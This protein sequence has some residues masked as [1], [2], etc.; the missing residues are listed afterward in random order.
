MIVVHNAAAY[1]A[2]WRARQQ[3]QAFQLLKFSSQ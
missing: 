1:T 3:Q 2:G